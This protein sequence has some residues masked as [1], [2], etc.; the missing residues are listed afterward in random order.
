MSRMTRKTRRFAAVLLV[1]TAAA[2]AAGRPAVAAVPAARK[3]APAKTP[4]PQP[5][6]AKTAR[7]ESTFAFGRFGNVAIYRRAPHPKNVVLFVSGD[8]GWNLGVIDMA[9]ALAGLDALVV[10]IDITHYLKTVEAARDSCTS[11][12]VDF[13][14]LSQ[15]VQKKLG[16]PDYVPPVLVG[17]SSGAT[18]VY[19]TLVQAPPNT[20]RG[21]ISLG[22]CPD[23][24]IKKPFCAGQGLAFGPGPKGK[25]VSFL[26]SDK[27]EAP[28]AALQGTAD[29][30][31]LPAETEKYVKQVRN[32]E[33]VLLP[34]VGHGFSVQARWMPQFKDTFQKM[35]KPAERAAAQQAPARRAAAPGAPAP[36]SVADLPLVEVPA[37]GSAGASGERLAVIIS[38]DG[39]WAGIDR[40]VGGALAARGIPVVGLNSLSYFW[41]GRTPDEIAKDLARILEHYFDAWG[42]QR[43]V[44]VGYSMGADVLP[45]MVDRLPEAL[46][47]RIDLV[48][49]LG[50]EKM[51]SFEFHVTQWLGG[52]SSTDR[53]VMPE[54]KR[55]AGKPRLL[56]LYG[57]NESDSICP[58]LDPALG[59][60]IGFSGSH[61]FGGNYDALA[62]RILQELPGHAAVGAR[63]VRGR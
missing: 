43:A 2:A 1:T 28:F 46:R 21:A 20:F 55:L 6:D 48:A 27:L 25:G 10:G 5:V 36:P 17:Y 18:L 62:D 39:G 32:G 14:G 23:L 52:G 51:A 59:K 19:A 58:G 30:T 15:Y 63:G 11:A 54:V 42:R 22:F 16:M 29:E 47:D 56:C 41:R 49:L 60:S 33:L 61:H 53:P 37:K 38:G 13:E 31:C 4:G 24:P 57:E 40:E 9:Q 35:A 8:G 45:F 12:A 3:A 50:P 26:P 34:K 7:A 44:L